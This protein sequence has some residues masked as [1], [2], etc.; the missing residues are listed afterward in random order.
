MNKY[1]FIILLTF[2]YCVIGNIYGLYFWYLWSQTHGFLNS[3]LIGPFV[4]I[5]K[6]LLW[7]FFM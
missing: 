2:I 1:S 3:L 4:G 6:G 7:P 5:F